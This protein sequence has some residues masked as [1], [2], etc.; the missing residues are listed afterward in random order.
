[1]SLLGSSKM[2]HAASDFHPRLRWRRLACGVACAAAGAAV[3]QFLGNSTRGYIGTASLFY[4][5]SFQWVNA[6]S[7]TQHGLPILG[8]CVALVAYNLWS[9]RAPA[10]DRG[11]IWPAVGAMVGGLC[12]HAVGFVAEQAR[13]SILGLLLFT[14]GAAAFAGGPRWARATA[15]PVSFMVFAIPWNALDSAGFWLRT[16]VVSASAGMVHAMGIPVLVNGT[17][18]M[19]PDGRYDYDVA[20]ACSGVRSLVALSA[21]SLLI[22]YLW[23]R[24]RWLTI[25]FFGLSFPLIFVGNVARIVAIV[26]AAQWGGAAWGDRVHAVMGF[27]VFAVV[28]G[29]VYLAA[30]RIERLRPDWA[31]PRPGRASGNSA[32]ERKPPASEASRP[33]G[34]WPGTLVTASAALATALFLA[35]VAALPARGRAGIALS[36]DGL[37]P[38]EL[39]AFLGSD[40]IGRR[41]DVSEVERELL[42]PDTGFSRRTYVLIADPSE[43]VFLSIV[44]SGHDRTSIHR[45]ELCLVGQGWTIRDSFTHRFGYPGD[46]R[47]FPSTVL[48]V[49]KE[50]ATRKG[51]VMI[52]QLVAYYFVGDDTVV[53]SHWDRIATDAWNRVA[54][55][56]ADRWAYVLIQTGASD[57]EDAALRRIQTVLDGTLKVFQKPGLSIGGKQT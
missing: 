13:V 9:Q 46:G 7:E 41:T 38:V 52:P 31:A 55:G 26:V 51:S 11:G 42:P 56:R 21:L 22:G 29:G 49:E 44:L 4:W 12:L 5:W 6:N 23:F 8:I 14:W 18:L 1:M 24:P 3:F 53:A 17:Q 57:G 34:V 45:P 35:H 36:P 54:H 16:W 10:V 50:I 48:R 15:F 30:A 40:W 47:G 25:V 33:V 2:T 28:L 39:P 43:Q 19:S 20:A 37:A 32:A 27:G